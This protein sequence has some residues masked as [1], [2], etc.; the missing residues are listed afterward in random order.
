MRQVAMEEDRQISMEGRVPLSV[1]M[2]IHNDR[3]TQDE[4][5]YNS[6]AG[7]EISVVFKS[8]DGAPP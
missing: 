3:R 1:Y 8:T 2:V 4:R 6:H 5:R 7:E